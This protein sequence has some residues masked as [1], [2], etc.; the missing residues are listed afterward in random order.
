MAI[1]S[2]LGSLVG[3]GLAGDD[4][5]KE[6]QQTQAIL[7][8]YNIAP[9]TI[10]EQQVALKKLAS[11]GE[12]TPEELQTIALGPTAME[13]VSADPRLAEA[14]L[15]TLSDLQ[16]Q[17]K[18]GLTDIDRAALNKVRRENERAD[19]SRQASIL[20]NMAQRG[21]A[22]SGAELAAQL[23]SSQAATERA[24]EEGDRL[25]ALN[26]ER[27]VQ[28]A[29]DVAN[30]AGGLRG[31]E[32]GEKEKIATAKDAISRFNA[33]NAQDIAKYN[34][35]GRNQGQLLNLQ[36]KQRIADTNVG[37]AN[38]EQEHN[39]S[40]YQQQF[41]NKLGLAS[42]KAGGHKALAGLAGKRAGQTADMWTNIG[43]GVEEGAK[44]L[45]GLP[46]TKGK[47]QL[48]YKGGEI[49]SDLKLMKYLHGGKV[50]GKAKVQGDSPINDIVDAKLSPGEIVIPR[51]IAHSSDEA[52]LDFIK[53][54]RKNSKGKK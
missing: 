54:V 37:L 38:K 42:G 53:Y 51:S 32:F 17:S 4:R 3:Y 24:S 16:T 13:G 22:G 33:A 11:V 41:Q 26:L 12:Y 39:K 30:L 44:A 9:P 52:I 48:A 14:Q 15:Q 23:A 5:E 2:I 25:A 36:E 46:S 50:E 47:T 29:R 27:R 19:R 35:S 6:E 8:A 49:K 40:L 21:M 28:A 10:E 45:S 34:V 7:D 31:Q 1:G 18:E 20:Q 43:S